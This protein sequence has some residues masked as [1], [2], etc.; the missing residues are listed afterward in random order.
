MVRVIIPYMTDR[1]LMCVP[2]PRFEEEVSGCTATVAILSSKKIFVVS[3][4]CIDVRASA[5]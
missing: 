5:D 2:D 4:N 1:K 3:L